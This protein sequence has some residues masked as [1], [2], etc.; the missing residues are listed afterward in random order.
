LR[1][2]TKYDKLDSDVKAAW[3]SAMSS[4]DGQR[5]I[6]N[7]CHWHMKRN[8][9]PPQAAAN[10]LQVPEIPE[11]LQDFTN[12]EVSLISKRIPFMKILGLPRGKQKAMHGAAVNVPCNPDETCGILPRIPSS[13]SVITI[14]LKRKLKYRG[15]VFHQTIRPWKI[16]RAL[17]FL[18]FIQKN[19]HYQDVVINDNWEEDCI[20]EDSNLWESLNNDT[21][22]LDESEE[23]NDN[24]KSDSE[25]ESDSENEN[26]T[27]NND[28]NEL[29]NT[30]SN[31]CGLPFDSCLQPKDICREADLLLSIAPGEGKKPHGI[32]SD[33]HSEEMSFPHLF[34]DGKFEFDEKRQSKL[35]LKQYF[36]ARLLNQDTCFACSTE[37][38]F[39]ARYRAEAKKIYDSISIAMRK[40]KS[41]CQ[42]K[43]KAGDVKE[44]SELRKLTRNDLNYHFLQRV[45]GSPAYYNKMMYDLLGMIRQLG[46]CTWFLTLVSGS[47]MERLHSSNSS[48]TWPNLN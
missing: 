19:P 32:H 43:I 13:S 10:N 5:Y 39:Y 25:G 2:E 21:S 31:L 9:M 16:K 8:R 48:S 12:L 44:A 3:I 34:P 14:K 1:D 46:V 4:N 20:S 18:K 28:F 26:S 6:C 42:E 35:S 30:K 41:G 24:D 11:E 22:H 23:N 38:L 7:I 17:H 27:E 37:Y 47:Y 33:L 36:N 15:H 45:R 40:T 29:L